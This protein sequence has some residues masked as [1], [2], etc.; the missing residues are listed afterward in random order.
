MSDL[1]I[2]RQL[3]FDQVSVVNTARC[4]EWHD[5]FPDGDGDD[6]TGADWSNAMQSEAG[7]AGNVVKKLRRMELG[8]QGNRKEGD[9]TQRDLLIQLGEEIAD[10]FIYLDLL[11]T[12]YGIDLPMAVV[13]KFNK[14]SDELD[15]DYKL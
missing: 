9:L 15:L 4:N 8:T 7:E 2:L 6:W 12:F 5:G 11:A 3:T 10:T 13:E 1:N 14:V